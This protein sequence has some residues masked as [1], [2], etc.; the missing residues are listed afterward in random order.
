MCCP[1]LN[2][3]W[4]VPEAEF[5]DKSLLEMRRGSNWTVRKLQTEQC[6]LK[7]LMLGC[8]W[9]G[10]YIPA[11]QDEWEMW[12][13][14]GRMCP[15]MRKFSAAERDHEEADSWRLPADTPRDWAASPSLK[16]DLGGTS[17]RLPV[18]TLCHS[19]PFLY[20]CLGT[21]PTE[22]WEHLSLSGILEQG[23]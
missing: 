22:S 16:V 2:S 7:H 21:A 5:G 4:T 12:A 18:Y 3:P 19:D 9:L 10:L 14:L 13:I 1:R 17:S 20:A 8:R 15:L 6:L 23:G 11:V